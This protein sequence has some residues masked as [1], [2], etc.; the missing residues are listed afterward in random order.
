MNAPAI[1]AAVPDDWTDLITLCMQLH[2]EN[3]QDDVDWDIVEADILRG[4]NKDHA[5]IGVIGPVGKIEGACLLTLAKHWYGK[6]PFLEER[7]LFVRPEFRRTGNAQALLQFAR[8]SAK[9]LKVKLLIG[10]ISNDRT[11][12]KL[13]LYSRKLGKPIG[14]FFWIEG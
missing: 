12:A 1:R 2:E 6:T 11:E 4:I 13:R 8:N 9:K 3:G 7:F 10:V 5:M 14:G